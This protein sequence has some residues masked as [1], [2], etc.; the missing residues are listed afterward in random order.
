MCYAAPKIKT[1]AHTEPH[2]TGS[3]M[4]Q[5]NWRRQEAKRLLGLLLQYYAGDG[6]AGFAGIPV[7][8]SADYELVRAFNERPTMFDLDAYLQKHNHVGEV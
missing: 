5:S 3:L 4:I 7:H 1:N 2:C 8:S 6:A